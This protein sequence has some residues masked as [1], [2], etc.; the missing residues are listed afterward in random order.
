MPITSF[1]HVN[2]RTAR[3][4]AM[5]AFYGA[6]LGLQPGPRPPFDFGGRWLYC[7][8]KPVLHLVE[9]A[10]HQEARSPRIEHFAFAGSGLADFLQRLR[11]AEVAYWVR[12]VPEW[13]TRQV[14]LHDPD[15]NHIHCDFGAHEEAD[16]S[17]F[18]PAA[19]SAA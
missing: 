8:D 11:D 17:A 1:D 16:L 10:A 12:V 19:S 9:I 14:N 5:V 13:G 6:I 2:V 3:L 7:G 18:D 4:E 15:G